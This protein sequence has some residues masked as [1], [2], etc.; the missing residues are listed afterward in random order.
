MVFHLH[1]PHACA[2]VQYERRGERIK[3]L[4]KIENHLLHLLHLPAESP[5]VTWQLARLVRYSQREPKAAA[6]RV[7]RALERGRNHGG[8]LGGAARLYAPAGRPKSENFSF[9]NDPAAPSARSSNPPTSLPRA[10][11]Q[12]L[13]PT[14]KTSNPMGYAST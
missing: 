2:L 9:L 12:R 6:S 4:S 5:G 14:S 1:H 11:P 7:F 10:I 3:I 8:A 13:I